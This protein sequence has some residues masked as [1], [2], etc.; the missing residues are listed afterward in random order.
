MVCS[1]TRFGRP[2]TLEGVLAVAAGVERRSEHPLARAIIQYAEAQGIDPADVNDFRSLTG[3]GASARYEQATVYVGSPDLFREKL[4]IPL[5]QVNDGITRLQAE[6]KTVVIVGNEESPW[7][8][9]AIRDNLRPQALSAVEAL[10]SVGIERIVML[11]GDNYGTA[12]AIAGE[13]G[14][15][16]FHAGLKPQDKVT[17]V[18]ELTERYGHVAMVGD[19][20]N[21][22]PALAEATVGVA[23]GAAGTDVALETADVALMAD[24]LE[25][26]VY[27]LRLA[28]RNQSV[29]NQ[30][31]MLSALVIGGLVIGAVTGV[32]SLPIAVLGHEISEFLVIGN[33]LRMLRG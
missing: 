4:R 19:G 31:L 1:H 11:T 29:V 13:A 8:L 3:A 18:R 22:A 14:V 6:G 23:M 33:G 9:I 30:N 27:A 5:G 24:D 21:D 2:A 10:R 32:F 28:R 20:V 26:L 7:G 17:K 15:D 25:K 12:H 16:E